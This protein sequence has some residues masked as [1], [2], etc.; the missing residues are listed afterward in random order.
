MSKATERHDRAV[1]R[2]GSPRQ[3]RS[4]A[5]Y[6]CWAA[7][8]AASGCTTMQPVERQSAAESI[9]PGD[10]V[11]V[12]TRDGRELEL[13][14]ADWTSEA[15]T[16]TDETGILQKIENED[17]ARVEVQRVSVAKSVG[18]GVLAAGV[19]AAA[20]GGGGDGY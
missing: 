12:D 16:G 10:A 2:A 14:F 1:M 3:A 8:L 17:I 13:V 4:L 19:V 7:M 18:L 20:A 6:L 9:E 15:L 5:V 11:F